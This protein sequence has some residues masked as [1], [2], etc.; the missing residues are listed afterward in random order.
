M[1]FERPPKPWT[2]A[3]PSRFKCLT[4]L[5]PFEAGLTTALRRAYAAPVSGHVDCFDELLAK[6]R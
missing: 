3:A 2:E 1:N 6:L 5:P 4:E